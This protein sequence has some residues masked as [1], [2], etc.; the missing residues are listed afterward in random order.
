MMTEDEARQKWC[1]FGEDPD[2]LIQMD[3]G[4]NIIREVRSKSRARCIASDCM[5]WRWGLKLN[6]RSVVPTYIQDREHGFCGA[7]GKP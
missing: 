3:A 7:A 1:P 6:E 2:P 5:A 4:G